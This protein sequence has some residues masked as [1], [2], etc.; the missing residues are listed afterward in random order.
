MNLGVGPVL[1]AE[2]YSTT[3]CGDCVSPRLYG[4]TLP[5]GGRGLLCLRACVCVSVRVCMFHWRVVVL[6]ACFVPA[7]ARV[8]ISLW[9]C[10]W[11]F[12]GTRTSI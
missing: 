7:A 6:T 11:P 3:V 1:E 10:I 2:L 4:R 8:F 5:W 12:R 9:P